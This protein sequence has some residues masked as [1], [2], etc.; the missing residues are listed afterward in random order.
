MSI[1]LELTVIGI[2]TGS[3][4]A[5]TSTGLVVTYT[6]SGIFNFAHGATGMVAAFCF[7]QLVVPWHVP[8]GLALVLVVFVG[9]PLFGAAVELLLM[10]NL[11]GAPPEISI[12]VTVGLMLALLGLASTVWSPNTYRIPPQ[13]FLGHSVRVFGIHITYHQVAVLAIVTVVAIGLRFFLHNTNA[14]TATRGVVDNAD[15]AAI[16]GISPNRYSRLGWAIGSSL[17]ALA[18]V[19]IAPL[20]YLT[21]TGLTLLVVQGYAAAMLGR[22]KNLPRTFIGGLL[23]GLSITYGTGYFPVGPLLQYV[24]PSIPIIFLFI[25]L[26]LIPQRSERAARQ[27]LSVL[28]VPRVP[29]RNESLISGAVFVAVVWVVTGQLSPANLIIAG[30]SLAY[31]VIALSLVPLVGYAGQISLCQLT[32]AGVGAVVA[33]HFNHGGSI[34]ALLAAAGVS[35][36]LGALV[37]LPALRVQGL[38]LALATLA[39]A[40]AM[41]A[42]FFSN[43]HVIGGQGAIFLQRFNLPGI[44][45]QGGRAFTVMIAVVFALLGIGVV[46]LRRSFLGRRLV[47][48]AESPA[49]YSSLGLSQIWTRL[50]VFALS[51]GIAGLGGALYGEQ[52]LIVTSN[53]FL[54]LTSLLLLLLAM[55]GGIRCVSGVLFA[56][57][58]LGLFPILQQ[59]LP[60]FNDVAFL[61]TGLTAI[62]LGRNPNGAAGDI[63]HARQQIREQR[64]AKLRAAQPQGS[65]IS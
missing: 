49:A 1:F 36:V 33:S 22:L 41:D 13:L 16:A 58:T 18:G 40:E 43:T 61:L 34:L 28:R 7:W 10:R 8:I 55:L 2:V 37:A 47:A 25:F 17:A 46:A 52:Q 53:D 60:Q 38:Y 32:F 62:S 15:L 35:A 30:H 51:A 50:G 26:L 65:G 27:R 9:A 12:V 29:G 54:Y 23:L 24:E 45:L 63:S 42:A 11:R 21:T 19:L 3:L 56:A 39:F 20:T 6:T 4:Y 57:V 64:R 31:A 59:H 5:L 44:S 14:G 48:L